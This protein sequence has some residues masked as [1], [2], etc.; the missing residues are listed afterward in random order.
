MGRGIAIGF[1][2][3]A[4][5]AAA[6][7][8]GVRSARGGTG[9]A[10]GAKPGSG[11]SEAAMGSGSDAAKLQA[12][13]DAVTAERASLTKDLEALDGKLAAARL[14]KAGR[15]SEARKSRNPWSKLGRKLY[16]LRATLDDMG[17]S[18][19]PESQKLMAE[20]LAIFMELGE[21]HKVPMNDLE[22]SPWVMPMLMLAILEGS[23][24]PPDGE[25]TAKLDA[26]IATAESAWSE[27][28]A[29]RKEMTALEAR[30]AQAGML[31]SALNGL[32]AEM[33]PEQASIFETIKIFNREQAGGY[34]SYQSGSRQEIAGNFTQQW[35][36]QIG[37]D[38][39]QSAVLTPVVTEYMAAYDA[40]QAEWKAKESS[41]Q[42]VN[43]FTK[44]MAQMDLM[45]AAQK[46]IEESVTL[47]DRQKKKLKGWSQVYG[48]E[49]K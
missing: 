36:A 48:Y 31:G 42:T 24:L 45:I 46:K 28:E 29:R 8:Y 15:D 25:Q 11:A 13:R 40:L 27:Y 38:P 39:S 49:V 6:L 18:G 7:F 10:P 5:L 34:T 47:D 16:E 2:L 14:A 41:G 1:L 23:D 4:V 3:G 35:A 19:D 33:T 12:D 26:V 9:E 22:G 32:R 20:I 44:S 43:G 17:E 21:K 30:R 37:L